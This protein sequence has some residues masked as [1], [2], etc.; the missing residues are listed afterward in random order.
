MNKEMQLFIGGKISTEDGR[1]FTRLFGGFGKD[2]PI[3]TIFQC[4]DLLGLRTGDIKDNFERNAS[5]FEEYVDFVD[6]KTANVQNVSEKNTGISRV[7]KEIGY[8]QNKL[9]ATKK[10]LAFSFAGMLKMVKISNTKESWEIY[11]RFLEDYFKTKAENKV[12]KLTIEEEIEKLK[13]DKAK[14]YGMMIMSSDEEMSFKLGKQLESINGRIVILEKSLTKEEVVKQLQPDLSLVDK[15]TS[16]EY[17]FDIGLIAKVFDVKDLGRNNL[18]K[19]LR[20][21][22]ILMNNNSPYQ[23]YNDY[24]KVVITHTNGFTSSKTLVRPKGISF[25]YKKLV[26]DGKIVMKSVDEIITELNNQ[27]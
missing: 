9:N 20:A 2:K 15:L 27:N 7:L 17:N 13:E 1:E 5:Q 18:F 19:W 21:K 8:S 12:M 4:A 10:W 14:V 3:F 11:D 16:G 6:L 25:L 26:E 23:K 22:K 24:F